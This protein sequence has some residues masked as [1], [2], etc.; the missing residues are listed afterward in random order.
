MYI[1]AHFREDRPEILRDA[2]RNI[3]LGT[4]VTDSGGQVEANH[5]PMLLDGDKLFGHFAKANFVWQ[6][7]EAGA[8]VLAIFLG[9]HFYT[10]PSWYPSKHETGKGVPTWNYIS[11]QV[12][13][14]ITLYDN[15][16]WLRAH[17]GALT[18]QQE[19]KR[20]NP[21][22]VEDAPAEYIQSLLRAIVGFEIS[23]TEMEGKW[24]MSQNRS[25]ADILGVKD[26]LTRE[27]RPDLAQLV[28][29]K[30]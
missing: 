23:I 5:I 2:V 3:G 4:L 14:R 7:L 29:P 21:W 24:K 28:P 17:V 9:P 1:P 26:A 30:S 20:V 19:Q 16:D 22:D 15:V 10:S 12:R 8:A 27:C 11:V 13:G 6:T 25:A 18:Q